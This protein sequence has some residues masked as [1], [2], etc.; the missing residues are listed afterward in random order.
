MPPK[1][2]VPA[3]R[4]SGKRVRISSNSII[5]STLVSPSGRK[6]RQASVGI[7]YKLTATR[8]PR[9]PAEKLAKRIKGAQDTNPA[10]PKRRGRPP[11]NPPVDEAA[12]TAT[13]SSSTLNSDKPARG[14]NAVVDS[15]PM[16]TPKSPKRKREVEEEPAPNPPRKRGRPPK[17]KSDETSKSPRKPLAQKVNTKVQ[18]QAGAADTTTPLENGTAKAIR[19]RGRPLGSKNKTEKVKP[20]ETKKASKTKAMDTADFVESLTQ[21]EDQGA[22]EFQYWLMKAEPDTRIEK[23]VDVAFSIDNLAAATEPEPW[24][25]T[26]HLKASR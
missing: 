4:A 24:D 10:G 2:K 8:S 9:M 15:L 23:G 5:P 14:K 13:K 6:M 26:C 19:K 17:P 12:V 16:D 18:A 20:K 25:G 3:R 7:S 11:V 22:P 21:P 1:T